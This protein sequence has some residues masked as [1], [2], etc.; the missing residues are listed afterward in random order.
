MIS[1]AWNKDW[2]QNEIV[3]LALSRVKTYTYRYQ[4]TL[5]L[6]CLTGTQTDV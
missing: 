4:L 5:C 2:K 3:S 6:V 1:L